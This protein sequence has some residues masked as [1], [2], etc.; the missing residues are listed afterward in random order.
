[1]WTAWMVAALL[2]AGPAGS[3]TVKG[4]TTAG[5]A[6]AKLK[7]LATVSNMNVSPSTITFVATD[8][9][10]G[11]TPQ[12]VTVTWTA[13]GGIVPW[14]LKG[15]ASSATFTGCPTVPVSAVKVTCTSASAPFLGSA[16]C[17]GATQLSTTA[18]Q[19]AGG[20]EALFGGNYTVT[21]T[22]TL[23]DSWK[24]IAKQIPQCTLNLTYTANLP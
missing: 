14:T 24:Y 18:A 16:N 11:V 19:I 17:S 1:M 23:A 8:P 5:P 21:L 3:A 7:P 22:L 13:T 4:H 2:G 9:D 10:L 20:N 15:M 6:A 12:A